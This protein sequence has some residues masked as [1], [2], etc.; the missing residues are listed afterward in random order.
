[1]SESPT[2]RTGRLGAL[3]VALVVAGSAIGVL[4]WHLL[5]NRNAG[6]I[7][8]AGFDLDKEPETQRPAPAASQ[9]RP[10]AP[11]SSLGSFKADEGMQVAAG[12]APA[13]ESRPSPAARASVANSTGL[14]AS[15]TGLS[16]MMNNPEMR[17]MMEQNQPPPAVGT[18]Q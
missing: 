8:N 5:A 7:D 16:D 4:G 18:G 10:A 2:A 12:N 14:P 1:M 15:I 17:K 11:R 13:R 6:S 9:S 3:F